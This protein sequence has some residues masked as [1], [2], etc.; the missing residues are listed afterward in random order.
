[1][2]ILSFWHPGKIVKNC[3]NNV[4]SDCCLQVIVVPHS[5]N[6]PGWLKTLSG[7]MEDQTRPTLNNMVNK[8]TKLPGMTFIWAESVFLHLWWQETD[9]ATRQKV[10]VIWWGISYIGHLPCCTEFIL[11]V[12]KCPLPIYLYNLMQLGIVV[13]LKIYMYHI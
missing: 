6:D 4:D 7:Y 13:C 8:L 5:H 1:M 2:Q 3:Q 10:G 9:D 12:Y 11:I